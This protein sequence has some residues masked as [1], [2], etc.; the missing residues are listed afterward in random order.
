MSERFADGAGR[1]PNSVGPL[2]LLLL[3]GLVLFGGNA[4]AARGGVGGGG[5]GGGGGG[6]FIVA[7]GLPPAVPAQFDVTGFLQEATLDTAGS[8]CQPVDPRLAGGTLKVNDIQVI[9]PCNTILQMPAST[10]TW[11]EVFGL[12]PRDIGLL[13]DG[14]GIPTQTGLALADKVKLPVSTSYNGPL[15]SY[16]VH[17]QGNIVDGKYIAGLIFISQQNLNLAQGIIT[18]IDYDNGE[19]QIATKGAQP[20]VARVKIN[21]PLGRYGLSH[22]A[23]GSAATLIEP[24]YDIRF[25]IDEESPTIH[26]ASGFPMCL[27]RSDPFTSGDDPDC[28]QANRPR[29]PDCA[30]LPAPFPTFAMPASGQYCNSFMM[31]PPGGG[32]AADAAS[33]PPDATRQAPFEVG[34]FIDYMGTLKVDSKGAYISAHTIVDHLGIYTSPGSMPAYLSI[35]ME[36]QGTAALAI[37]NLPQESTSRIKIE[38]FSTDPSALVD[39]FAVDVDPL[40]G[41]I[42]DRLLGVANPSG[43]PVIG[44]FRFKPFSGAFLPP[45]RE[46]RVVSRTLCGHPQQACSLYD[47]AALY[48]NGIV[49]GQ[50]H[51]PNFEF[52]FPENLN[53]GDAVVPANFQDLI[54][55]FCGSGPLSTPTGAGNPPLVG[56]LDPPP[57]AAPMDNPLFARLCPNARRVGGPVVNATTPVIAPPVPV[58][59]APVVVPPAPVVAAPAPAVVPVTPAVV[60]PAVATP[61]PVVATPTPVSVPVTSV[62][63][64][65]GS[66]ILGGG[67]AGIAT[68]TPAQAANTAGQPVDPATN[69]P[70]Q[71]GLLAPSVSASATPDIVDSNQ[72]VILS[73]LASDPNTPARPLSYTWT[74]VGFP[75]VAINNANT[76]TATFTAPVVTTPTTLTFNVAVRNTVPLTSNAT[77]SVLVNPLAH[78]PTVS[79]NAPTS[80]LAGSRVAMTGVVSG[81]ATFAWKQTAGPAVAL[82]N[83]ALLSVA[84]IAPPGPTTLTFELTATNTAGV[85]ASAVRSIQVLPD[86]VTVTA[87][88]WDNR[89]GKGRLNVVVNSS[90]INPA[91]P[92]PT[93]GMAMVASFWNASLP[94]SAPGSESHPVSVPMILV[95][96]RP[97]Q[98]P[99]CGS[100][101]PCF[102]L[103][104]NS[105]ILARTG[106]TFVPPSTVLVKS[107]LGGKASVSGAKIQVR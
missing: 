27:P 24:G 50:Y 88:T 13:L 53:L 17:V 10:L 40:T 15:P 36:L 69:P 44:R 104:Q 45:T 60:T 83:G 49:A 51:A 96:D 94:S 63:T 38:G 71:P 90:V 95:R 77:V 20:G 28:P 87:A 3:A 73:A 42:S 11:Q 4:W 48:A 74:Q 41:A 35:E 39:I 29:A 16:E 103:N 93:A 7:G 59:P 5:A 6:A 8:I 68:T 89:Q 72:I 25:S 79:F 107:S 92:T 26:A 64:G 70:P 55:L 66:S 9:V 30:S 101:L 65:A 100:P 1:Y 102:Q 78:P 43:P 14:N 2:G 91:T 54:F 75:A 18:A 33:C 76:E 31:P 81:G 57:W 85:S 34:D 105:V 47:G 99:V 19:L 97:G 23:P 21:D 67:T 32:C 52:I 84:F 22:G 37:A 12:A 46:F 86:D 80:V 106:A 62:A 58:V 56:Q 61:T 82:S 98:E